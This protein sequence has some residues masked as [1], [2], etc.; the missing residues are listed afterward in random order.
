VTDHVE[1]CSMRASEQELTIA[2]AVV[3]G[4][5]FSC[6]CPPKHRRRM[7]RERIAEHRAQVQA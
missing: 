4:V 5:G 3:L 7:T 1:T 2:K 6:S